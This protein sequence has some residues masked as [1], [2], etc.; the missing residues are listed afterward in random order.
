[1]WV[2][3][4]TAGTFS[5]ITNASLVRLIDGEWLKDDLINAY[6]GHLAKKYNKQH[7]VSLILAPTS[8]SAQKAHKQY[9]DVL[10]PINPGQTH[11]MLVRLVCTETEQRME[12]YD[13]LDCTL[14][15]YKSLSEVRKLEKYMEF[16][17]KARDQ[18]VYRVETSKKQMDGSSCGLF[19]LFNAKSICTGEQVPHLNRDLLG[20]RN[21]ILLEV[22]SK[23]ILP[24][25]L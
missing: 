12:F 8:T 1:V 25:S 7:I 24:M 15:H 9:T 14:S 19:T 5:E 11:W 23:D 20:Y 2:P 21:K 17:G 3:H 4:F 6:I 22:L 13:S 10:V 16:Y 18:W